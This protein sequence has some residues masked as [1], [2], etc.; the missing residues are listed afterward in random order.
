MPTADTP[1]GL[2]RLHA[3]MEPK[4]WIDLVRF[5]YLIFAQGYMQ[6][7]PTTLRI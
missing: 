5:H 3:F 1:T 2:G 6:K 7:L 4:W